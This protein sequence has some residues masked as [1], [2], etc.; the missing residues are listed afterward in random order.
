MPLVFTWSDCWNQ[1]NINRH[2][3]FEYWSKCLQIEADFKHFIN[4]MCQSNILCRLKVLLG[5]N[6]STF[7]I[8][9]SIDIYLFP[10][11]RLEQQ[12]LNVPWSEVNFLHLWLKMSPFSQIFKNVKSKS[13]KLSVVERDKIFW[14]PIFVTSCYGLKCGI[15]TFW[16]IKPWG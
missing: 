5:T 11:I 6:P 10:A 16:I 1:I 13:S 8:F 7:K 15:V 9:V 3:N 2:K 4:K 12:N 14:N